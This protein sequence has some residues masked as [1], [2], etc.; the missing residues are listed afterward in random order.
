MREG[1]DLDLREKM[2]D[3]RRRVRD[4]GG[5]AIA[6]S[7]GVDSTLLIS[8]AAEELGDRALAVTAVSPTYPQREREESVKLAAQLGIRQELVESNELDIPG[9]AGNPPDRCY[10]CKSEL[11]RVVREVAARHGIQH[12]ADGTNADDT[13]DYRPGCRA[14]EEQDVMRPLLDARLGKEEIRELSRE[15]GLPTAGKPAFACLAS[16]FPYGAAITEEGLSAVDTVERG[17]RDLGFPQVRV[18]HHGDTARIEVPPGDIS[19]ITADENRE[20]VVALGKSAGFTYVT[21]DLQGYRTG[22]MN[23][24]LPGR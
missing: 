21:I 20:K 9:F 8:V 11:F 1:E 10:H 4:T 23:E 7:G 18:R 12:V 16:R 14:A 19:R 24:V 22:S 5:L 3:L 15:L 13:G 6:F 2:A 17:V